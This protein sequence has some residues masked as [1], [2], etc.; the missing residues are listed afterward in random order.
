MYILLLNLLDES[1]NISVSQM[2]SLG[3][4][5]KELGNVL[6]SISLKLQNELR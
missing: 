6:Q 3:D 4:N 2:D 1:I 5:K